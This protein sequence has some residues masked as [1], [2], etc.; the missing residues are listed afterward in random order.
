[1]IAPIGIR[2][3]RGKN[4]VSFPPEKSP[5]TLG[6]DIRFIHRDDDPYFCASHRKHRASYYL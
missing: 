3:L 1:M 5:D 4:D 6:S 2:F